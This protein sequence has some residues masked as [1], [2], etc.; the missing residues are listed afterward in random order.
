MFHVGVPVY[1]TILSHFLHPS[2][3]NHGT[4]Q[5]EGINVQA[6]NPDTFEPEYPM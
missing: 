6:E 3:H 2:W 4:A 1:C 5:W